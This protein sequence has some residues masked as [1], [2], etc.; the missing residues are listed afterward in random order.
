MEYCK[1]PSLQSVY[2]DIKSRSEVMHVVRCLLEAVCELHVMGVC[3]RDLKPQ[4]ILYDRETGCIKIID[5][6]ISKL[7]YNLK[8]NSK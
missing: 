1:Y 3:H 2:R 6:G 5:L 4:N 8:T 7:L